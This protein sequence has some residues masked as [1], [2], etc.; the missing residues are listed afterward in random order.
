MIASREGHV[1]VVRMLLATGKS[2]LERMNTWGHTALM[3]A[4]LKGH[5]GIVRLITRYIL[6]ERV[7][8]HRY[9]MFKTVHA[10]QGN[11]DAGKPGS[12]VFFF[13][14]GQAIGQPCSLE[15]LREDYPDCSVQNHKFYLEGAK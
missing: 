3:Y 14:M 9:K 11:V 8:A 5:V 13:N 2:K 12:N 15:E 7:K 10:W 6:L 4:S 1:E